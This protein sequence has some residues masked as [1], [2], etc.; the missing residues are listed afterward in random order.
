MQYVELHCKSNFS[1]LEGAS[2]ADEL[3]ETAAE[4][5][6]GGLAVTDRNSLAGIVRAHTAA[7][8]SAIRLIVGAELHP[9]DG[10]PIVVWPENRLGYGNLSRIITRGRLRREKGACEIRWGDIAELNEGL[11]A[12]MLL[13]QPVT[14]ELPAA[15]VCIASEISL[16]RARC[17]WLD[18]RVK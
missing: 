13:R 11:L 14:D 9:V 16:S 7:N 8:D 17:G 2:H 18:L 4:L 3:M 12:G 15:Q 10:P 6:Y 5:G 1:F